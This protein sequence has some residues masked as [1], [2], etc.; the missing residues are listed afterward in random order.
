M[1]TLALIII[2][3]VGILFVCLAVLILS[4]NKSETVNLAG[5]SGKADKWQR[6][7]NGYYYE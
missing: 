6:D 2:G 7:N 5:G 3:I 4:S 1:T